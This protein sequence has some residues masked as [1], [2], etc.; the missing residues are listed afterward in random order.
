M[1]HNY[2]LTCNNDAC[3]LRLV[4]MSLP[5]RQPL[6]VS[7]AVL[8]ALWLI[9]PL[10]SAF[11]GPHA[12]RYCAE[13]RAIEE[14][15]ELDATAEPGRADALAASD[16]ASFALGASAQGTAQESHQ[17]CPFVVA[18]Q[19]DVALP[20]VEGSG[21]LTEGA[22]QPVVAGAEPAEPQIPLL[23]SAPKASPPVV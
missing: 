15:G 5:T 11:H 1:Q 7:A 2:G 17:A 6:R 20:G 10:L 18:Q 19:R 3:T 21:S 4:P 16:G 14:A 12:H 9:V 22:W 8:A 13:H 23:A